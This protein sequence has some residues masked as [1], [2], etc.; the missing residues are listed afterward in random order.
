MQI[1]Q[2]VGVSNYSF[3]NESGEQLAGFTFHLVS[4]TPEDTD[5]FVGRRVCTE[6]ALMPKVDAWR[7][8]GSLMPKVG[9]KVIPLYTRTGKLESFISSSVLGSS[10]E[11]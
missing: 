5:R 1:Y 11:K 9:D 6:A 4:D 2:V 8:S 7:K 3:K 10:G